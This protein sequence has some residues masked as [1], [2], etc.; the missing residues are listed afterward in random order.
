MVIDTMIFIYAFFSKG[1]EHI[2]SKTI[3]KKAE[4]I[5]VPDLFYSEFANTTWQWVLHRNT[6]MVNALD[7]LSMLDILITHTIETKSVAQKS[8]FFAIERN[9]SVYDSIFV[10]TAIQSNTKVVSFD[11]K[12]LRTFPEYSVHPRVFLSGLN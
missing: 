1:Q 10:E 11:K 9:H 2:D 3:L 5:I 7:A 8:L 6:P 12:L 4:R